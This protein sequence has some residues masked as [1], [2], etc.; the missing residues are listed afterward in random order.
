LIGTT[1]PGSGQ[2]LGLF[3]LDSFNQANITMYDTHYTLL[4]VPPKPVTVDTGPT[5]NAGEPEGELDIEVMHAL[6]PSAP[7]T[8]WEGPNTDDGPPDT[9]TAMVTSDTT[10]ST[11]SSS[12]ICEPHSTAAEMTA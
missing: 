8:V 11:P 5:P 7:I 12:G 4:T 9:Y 2:S 3:E 6:A 1:V 10:P